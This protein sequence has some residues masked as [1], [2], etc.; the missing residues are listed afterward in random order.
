MFSFCTKQTFSAWLILSIYS[1]DQDY[2]NHR[3]AWIP[4]SLSLS[5]LP[6][7]TR[8]DTAIAP[9]SIY[10]C[11]LSDHLGILDPLT[12]R[13]DILPPLESHYEE[14]FFYHFIHS[15][16]HILALPPTQDDGPECTISVIISMSM[17]DPMILKAVLSLGASHMINNLS[18]M[19]SSSAQVVDTAPLVSEKLRLLGEVEQLQ[20]S[21]VTALHTLP[22]GT[23]EKKAG[24]DALL[25]SY[26][27]L[28]LY[29]FSEGTGDASWQRQLDGARS[30][31]SIAWTEYRGATTQ[32]N[33]D[34]DDGDDDDD[35]EE[36]ID[37]EEE[38][39]G[40]D[41]EQLEAL[42]IDNFLMQFFIYHDILTRVTV[43]RPQSSLLNRVPSKDSSSPSSSSSAPN[44]NRKEHMFGVYNGLID[45]ILRIAV[46]RTEA[47]A[48]P[49]LPGTVISQAVEIWQDID[50]WRQPAV[51]DNE[52]SDDYQHMCD[53]YI[54]ASFLWLFSIVYPDRVADEKVQ[55]MV[56]KGLESLSSIEAPR[57]LSFGLFPVFVIGMACIHEQSRGAVEEQLDHI[58]KFCQFRNIQL[59]RDVIRGAWGVC[60]SGDGHSWDWIRLMEGQR[61]SLP[62]T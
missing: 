18:A 39:E 27:L 25:A 26:L 10:Q 36:E 1:K 2:A 38:E 11:F 7:Q 57:M 13:E 37:S 8:F 29:E 50:N 56:Q 60:D 17:D 51:S 46:L 21:G 53:A 15:T 45:I 16:S 61:V 28:F 24:Y 41:R 30:V 48:V 54:A 19:S 3:A 5:S 4:S 14:Q 35:N 52:L 47:N 49:V 20:S 59:C 31:V 22:R 34:G 44:F 55:T 42:D 58:E 9:I 43:Q 32:G 33:F 6:K 62:I 23:M 12:S 40:L